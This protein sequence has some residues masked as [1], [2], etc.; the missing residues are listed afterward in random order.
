MKSNTV[1]D[2]S[3]LRTGC[4]NCGLAQICQFAGDTGVVNEEFE[5]M[6][7]RGRKIERGEH[8]FR[9]GEA[10]TRIYALRS[11]SVKTYASIEDGKEQVTGFHLPGEFLGLDSISTDFYTE[12]A[13][14]LETCSVCELPFDRLE[15]LSKAHPVIQHALLYAMSE[16]IQYDHRQLTLVSRMPAEA[17]LASFLLSVSRH[18]EQRGFSATDF[19]ISMTRSDIA[20]LLGLAVETVSR[21]FSQFQDKGLL[22]VERRHI[23][24]LDS[25]GLKRLA[26]KYPAYAR[27]GSMLHNKA[28]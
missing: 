22:A 15:N 20:N 9:V 4:H 8:I 11:G 21:I 16:E 27:P 25:A 6:I 26:A 23:V 3:T 17:R 13:I 10:F 19:N 12:S 18:F 7:K 14:A 2:L 28:S 5:K 24:L 1:V